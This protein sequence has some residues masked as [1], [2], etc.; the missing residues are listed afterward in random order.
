MVIKHRVR[1]SLQ[2]K[3]F[4]SALQHGPVFTW[5]ASIGVD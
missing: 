5:A 3:V 4:R 1:L 2:K